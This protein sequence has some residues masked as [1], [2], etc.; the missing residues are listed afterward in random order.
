MPELFEKLA[1]GTAKGRFPL[2]RVCCRVDWT[3]E[4]QSYV[5]YVIEF[6]ARVN[7][8]WLHHGD[9]AIRTDHLGQFRGGKCD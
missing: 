8:V 3:V 1:S 9:A 4:D 7:D 6:A 2:G 5:D